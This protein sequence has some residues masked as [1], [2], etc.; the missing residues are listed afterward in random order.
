MW[1]RRA[2]LPFFCDRR[3]MLNPAMLVRP[4]EVAYVLALVLAL[5]IAKHVPS[6]EAVPLA[7]ITGVVCFTF[8]IYLS[9]RIYRAELRRIQD[10]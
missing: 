9:L 7:N 3:P 2:R 4:R 8:A 5:L 6:L 1:R 10:K